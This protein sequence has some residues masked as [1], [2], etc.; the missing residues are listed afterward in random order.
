MEKRLYVSSSPHIRSKETVQSVMRDV[1]LALLPAT[2][3]GVITFGTRALVLI[4]VAILAAVGTEAFIQHF[5]RKQKV[6]IK[7]FSAVVTGLLL[8]MNIPSS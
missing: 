5:M 1:L 2:I 3:F 7:D 6:T 8:A 4:I